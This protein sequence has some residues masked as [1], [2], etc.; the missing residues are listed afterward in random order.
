MSRKK[1]RQGVKT[2]YRKSSQ[3]GG[4]STCY[5]RYN[6]LYKNL[7]Q[8]I[9]EEQIKNEWNAL[10]LDKKKDFNRYVC[11]PQQYQLHKMKE[12]KDLEENLLALDEYEDALTEII[13]K[14]PI[15]S[16]ISPGGE[17]IDNVIND[18]SNIHPKFKN[19]TYG[20]FKTS[21][22]SDE[23]AAA[24]KVGVE[25][26]DVINGIL[27]SSII[28]RSDKNEDTEIIQNYIGM[29]GDK[30]IDHIKL[31]KDALEDYKLSLKLYN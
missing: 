1:K 10:E 3:A 25:L 21:N 17:S 27:A 6:P 14:L 16:I 9:T 15:S 28:S 23:N 18:Y 20:Y 12:M 2:L 11:P 8:T 4:E 19:Y 30:S 24:A 13:D 5:G 22:M 26:T 7:G 31:E 29:Y